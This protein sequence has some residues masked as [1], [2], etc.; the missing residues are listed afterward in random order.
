MLDLE[1]YGSGIEAS[2]EPLGQLSADLLGSM[3][4]DTAPVQLTEFGELLAAPVLR[5]GASRDERTPCIHLESGERA[6]WNRQEFRGPLPRVGSRSQE[7]SRV[8]VHRLLMQR[9]GGALLHKEA[10]I[11][12]GDAIA[13]R[14]GE[15]EVVRNEQHGEAALASLFV[16][17]GRR[18]GLRRNV[19]R[20]RRFIGEDEA[21]FGRHR[22][23][24]NDALKQ[25]PGEIE[26]M[27]LKSTGG[28]VDSYVTQRPI[29]TSS[30]AALSTSKLV[31]RASVR[32]SPIVR[33]GL[34]CGV[35]P[36]K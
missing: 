9:P 34:T 22:G 25:S 32:K 29:T 30:A 10:C 12:H 4:R 36:R 28:V 15:L 26:R 11:H 16:Q 14:G 17:N 8:G 3:A 24:D 7:S 20:R 21:R 5:E 2:P 1:G 18:L 27:L 35:G 6:P 33:T 23:R 19:E 13:D 31:I